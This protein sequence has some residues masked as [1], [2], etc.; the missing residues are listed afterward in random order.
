MY[1]RPQSP[2]AGSQWLIEAS[3]G[4]L[5]SPPLPSSAAHSIDQEITVREPTR[6]ALPFFLL[7]LGSVALVAL[8]C[9]PTG[10]LPTN[11]GGSS[12]CIVPNLVGQSEDAA[13]QSLTELGLTP[14]ETNQYSDSF[15]AGVVIRTDPPPSTELDPCE[16]DVVMSISLGSDAKEPTP[17]PVPAPAPE[18]TPTQPPAPETQPTATVPPIDPPPMSIRVYDEVFDYGYVEAFRPEWNVDAG[19]DAAFVNETGQLVTQEYVAA[20]IGDESWYDYAIKFGGGEYTQVTGFH[21]MIRMQDEQNYVGIDCFNSEGYLACEGHRTVDGQPVGVPNFMQMTTRMCANG[22]I[23][24]DIELRAVAN[25]FSVVVNGER[26]GSMTDDTFTA[27]GAGFVVDGRWVVEY[28]HLYEP[29][30]PASAGW[31]LV[32]DDF[33]RNQWPTGETEDEIT[34]TSRDLLSDAYRMQVRALVDQV[35]MAYEVLQIPVE[36]NE[37]GFPYEFTASVT[38]SKISGPESTGT[39][40]LFGCRDETHCYEFL[41]VPDMGTAW[42]YQ[43]SEG[44]RIEIYGPAQLGSL[45]RHDNVLTVVGSQGAYVFYINDH[46]AFTAQL[47]DAGWPGIG[48]SVQVG[49][50]NYVGVAEF[51]NILVMEP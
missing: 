32:R 31:T 21:A 41:V 8:A 23:Q 30:K 40:L 47:D 18:P 25:E 22:Q 6:V 28:I 4:G 10:L 7:A 34:W 43:I 46:L 37:R 45:P 36:F 20:Y 2:P 29:L 33:S 3:H 15:A 39:G 19:P 42:I 38:A 5:W 35:V 12:K 26:K 14:V 50:Q 49:G 17:T 44:Q 9:C 11:Q 24:C 1:N 48:L 27:G 16:G 51:D 13:R